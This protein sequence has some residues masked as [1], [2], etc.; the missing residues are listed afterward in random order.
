MN[1]GTVTPW[2]SSP[3]LAEVEAES[4]QRI[5]AC[6]QCGK[7][8]AGCPAAYVMDW[9]PRQVMRAVQ[10]G[11]KEEALSSSGIWLCLYCH[12]CSIR[13]PREIDVAGVMAS[14]RSLALAEKIRP[15][16]P[17]VFR[18]HQVF[19][20]MVRRFGRLYEL[21]LGTMYNIR[22]RSLTNGRLVPLALARGKLPL[23]PRSIK[24]Q[25]EVRAIFDRVAALEA[26]AGGQAQGP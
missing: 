2:P 3:F 4:G 11:L 9:T 15:A 12:T 7:C 10:L 8:S 20:Q 14:L 25:A 26:N 18:F 13:C 17:Q 6:Y 21:G 24:G 19:G 1:N 22:S 23:L 16:V 5:K